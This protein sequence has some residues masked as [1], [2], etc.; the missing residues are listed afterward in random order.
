MLCNYFLISLGLSDVPLK[1]ILSPIQC[2]EFVQQELQSVS[3]I[4][5]NSSDQLN[6]FTRE[7]NVIPTG[8]E[9]N[10]HVAIDDSIDQLNTSTLEDN[11]IPTGTEGNKHVAID[12]SIDQLNTISVQIPTGTVENKHGMRTKISF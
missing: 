9:E 1:E 8:T 10:K 7:D 5:D 4:L 6:T 2:I 11:V 3:N 12:D